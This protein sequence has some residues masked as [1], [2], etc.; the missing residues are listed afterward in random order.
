MEGIQAAKLNRK[1]VVMLDL[2]INNDAIAFEVALETLGQCRQPFMQAIHEEQSKALPSE[3]LIQ[4]Y[5][6]RLLALDELQDCITPQ[7]MDAVRRILDTQ[8]AFRIE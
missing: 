4:Y 6:T 2:G 7:D 3:A 8:A 1:G 5:K